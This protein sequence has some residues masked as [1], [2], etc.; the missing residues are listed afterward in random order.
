[1]RGK[2]R[3]GKMDNGKRVLNERGMCVEQGRTNVHDRSEW[4]AVVNAWLM[5]RPWRP[6]EEALMHLLGPL[7]HISCRQGESTST[8]WSGRVNLWTLLC[9]WPPSSAPFVWLTWN[10][11]LGW[12]YFSFP[13]GVSEKSVCVHSPWSCGSHAGL[14]IV[15]FYLLERAYSSL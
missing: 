4:K 8:I 5:T 7:D 6:L 1:M 2:P 13:M 14:V 9:I 15:R 10:T 11:G 12:V 3:T